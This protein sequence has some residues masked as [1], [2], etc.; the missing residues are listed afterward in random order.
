[1]HTLHT[2]GGSR[3]NPGPAAIGYLLY[4]ENMELVDSKG[5]FLGDKLTN[6]FAEYHALIAGLQLA[7]KHGVHELTC[8]LD[9]ELVVKQVRGE[10]K[11]KHPDI[12]PL[13]LQVMELT[14]SFKSVKFVHVLREYNKAAD[15]IVNEVLDAR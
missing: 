15:K 1:M 14:H 9:S 7:I 8:K 13:Y 12:K 10:Y 11:V 4:D 2:D 3:G 5:E 6:N